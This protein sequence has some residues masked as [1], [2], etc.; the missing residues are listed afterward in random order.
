MC[1]AGVRSP[2]EVGLAAA[3]IDEANSELEDGNSAL[4]SE[5][6]FLV[7]MLARDAVGQAHNQVPTFAP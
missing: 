3:E 1:A 2:S 5:D 4:L 6:L 7:E